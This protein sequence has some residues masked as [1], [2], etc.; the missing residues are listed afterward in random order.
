MT[1]GIRGHNDPDPDADAGQTDQD[2][3]EAPETTDEHTDTQDDPALET[4]HDAEA[5][6][7]RNREAH[8]R[9]RAQAAEAERD[10]LRTQIDAL[11]QDAVNG[12]ATAAGVDPRLLTA[13]GH[14]LTDFLT[15]DGRVDRTTVTEACAK[16]AAEFG[17]RP[18]LRSNPQQG[19]RG[20]PAKTNGVAGVINEALGR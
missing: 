16:A 3:A 12:I 1:S 6:G 10:Q 8:Y 2:T 4:D 17:V 9:R 20:V 19:A 18:G 13:A 14:Q 11:R 15:D 5:G 7:R